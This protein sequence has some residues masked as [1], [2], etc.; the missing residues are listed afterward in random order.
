[1]ASVTFQK[2]K[3]KTTILGKEVSC[4][5][6]AI[7]NEDYCPFCKIEQR[8]RL[9]EGIEQEAGRFR[10]RVKQLFRR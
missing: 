4:P 5:L 6:Q 10:G 1:M 2:C 8:V 3:G 9:Q 7:P